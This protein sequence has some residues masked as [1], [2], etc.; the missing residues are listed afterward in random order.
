MKVIQEQKT[1][2]HVYTVKRYEAEDGTVFDDERDC[3]DYDFRILSN[4]RKPPVSAG[5]IRGVNDDCYPELI[6]LKTKEDYDYV[7]AQNRIRAGQLDTDFFDLG[8]GWYLCWTE[9]GGDYADSH[10]IKNYNRYLEEAKQN[11]EEWISLATE[12]ISD[13]DKTSL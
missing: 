12:A 8:E 5:C 11:L 2:T 1:H 4:R 10:Y 6:F 3:L 9:D 7:I 13:A